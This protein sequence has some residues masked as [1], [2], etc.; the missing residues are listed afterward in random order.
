MMTGTLSDAEFRYI[1]DHLHELPRTPLSSLVVPSNFLRYVHRRFASKD[2]A[3]KG[4]YEVVFEGD[5]DRFDEARAW[6]KERR[7]KL[8]GYR[9]APDD[10]GN[11]FKFKRQNDAIMFKLA[12]CG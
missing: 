8:R 4:G 9:C 3:H 6:V 12:W 5:D 7:M 2:Y 1:L 10:P 11:A